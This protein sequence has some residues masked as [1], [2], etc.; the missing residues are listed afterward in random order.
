MTKYRLKK[1]L[2]H[3]GIG[4]WF[5][6][7]TEF[8]RLTNSADF[9]CKL[10]DHPSA[11][12]GEQILKR[13]TDFFE[14]VPEKEFTRKDMVYFTMRCMN[15][16]AHVFQMSPSEVE[17]QLNEWLNHGRQTN[18]EAATADQGKTFLEG[19]TLL[20]PDGSTSVPIMPDEL[21]KIIK[22]GKHTI[23]LKFD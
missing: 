23:R 16:R 14:E 11:S 15:T 10:F 5:E 20:N 22:E 4:V 9:Y 6:E 1:R 21:I 17:Y 7:G 19:Y 18:P 12:I 8:E 3:P 13:E 2:F